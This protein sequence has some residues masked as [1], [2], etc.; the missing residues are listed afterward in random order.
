MLCLLV[1]RWLL[2][3]HEFHGSWWK[4][5][6]WFD[7]QPLQVRGRKRQEIEVRR[8]EKQVFQR[9]ET[10]IRGRSLQT[11]SG[12]MKTTARYVKQLYF[13]TLIT[14]KTQRFIHKF[15]QIS[16]FNDLFIHHITWICLSCLGS[17]WGP[18]Q[19]H[20][21]I[22]SCSR[23]FALRR[24]PWCLSMSCRDRFAPNFLYQCDWKA[25]SCSKQAIDSFEQTVRLRNSCAYRSFTV[26]LSKEFSSISS[27]SC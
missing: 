8:Q 17:G 23:S 26:D 3:L 20:P 6:P 12:P 16:S 2:N 27:L 14:T 4:R 25:H 24:K 1:W 5:V 22:R 19:C 18:C 15:L 21:P 11:A 7:Q 13:H 10:Q 9:I